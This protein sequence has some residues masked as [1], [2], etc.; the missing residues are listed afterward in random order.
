MRVA[1]VVGTRNISQLKKNPKGLWTHAKQFTDFTGPQI[2]RVRRLKPFLF[3]PE[4]SG[5]IF[6][7]NS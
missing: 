6:L 4:I 5:A 7:T 3:V 1:Q 2:M